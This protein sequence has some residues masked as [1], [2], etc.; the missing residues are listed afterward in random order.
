[1]KNFPKFGEILLD[2]NEF[3]SIS[4]SLSYKY[5]YQSVLKCYHHTRARPW[6]V[7]AYCDNSFYA[8]N[9][10]EIW[11]FL[12][13]WGNSPI[14]KF[15]KNLGVPWL[16]N[17]FISCQLFVHDFSWLVFNFF[18]LCLWLTYY[19][20]TY[21]PWIVVWSPSCYLYYLTTQIT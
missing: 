5:E 8:K 6:I 9:K 3:S 4:S 16:Y 21:P 10:I 18:T 17:L 19:H 7:R 14:L 11:P 12:Q 13:I 2:K 15:A 20:F 1:M